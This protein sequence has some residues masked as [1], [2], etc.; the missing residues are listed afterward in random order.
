MS[1]T[2]E[3]E[4]VLALQ[5]Y[6]Y[7]QPDH[8]HGLCY[9]LA[10]LKQFDYGDPYFIPHIQSYDLISTAAYANLIPRYLSHRYLDGAEGPTP[11]RI[12]LA[13]KLI[14]L[15]MYGELFYKN[16]RWQAAKQPA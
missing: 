6:I 3:M 15:I 12:A 8:P 2:R 4:A 5:N 7:A 13:K 9:W 11:E 16:K 14:K 1:K 10:R